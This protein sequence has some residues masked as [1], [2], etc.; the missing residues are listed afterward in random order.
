MAVTE[1]DD[2]CGLR[3]PDTGW[4]CRLPVN[5]PH[6]EHRNTQGQRWRNQTITIIETAYAVTA[7]PTDDPEVSHWTLEVKRVEADAWVIQWG[8]RH[9]NFTA[10]EWWYLHDYGKLASLTDL[11]TAL[12]QAAVLAPQVSVNGKTA[13]QLLAWR[14]ER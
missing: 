11:D 2:R 10:G 8:G 4:P 7:L 5:P 14:A 13:A 9:W 12:A 3:N 1:N 6:L